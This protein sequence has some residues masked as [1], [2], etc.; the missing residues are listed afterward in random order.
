M[1]SG[2]QQSSANRVRAQQAKAAAVKKKTG[3][4]LV[5]E[6]QGPIDWNIRGL[7]S[8]Y[9]GEVE[10]ENLYQSWAMTQSYADE[11]V[12]DGGLIL[13]V[14]RVERHPLYVLYNRLLE[15]ENVKS[16]KRT[17]ARLR[18]KRFVLDVQEI[19]LTNL[20]HLREHQPAFF[21][22]EK[23]DS[24]RD[25]SISQNPLRCYELRPY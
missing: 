3:R 17:R 18:M 16:F 25:K 7:R 13:S 15:D 23:P 1:L 9:R 2:K 14:A 8:K 11:A 20:Q 4:K 22:Q 10:R 12:E 19:W 21:L 6:P 5:E 24:G